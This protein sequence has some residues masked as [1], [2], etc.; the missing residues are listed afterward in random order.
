MN[1]QSPD[2]RP[3]FASAARG[4]RHVFVNRLAVEASIGIHQHEKQAKQEIWLTIDAG[5]LE[6][7]GDTPAN[8]ADVVCYE[9]ICKTATAL[10]TDGHIDLVETLAEN[11][12][13]ALMQDTRIVQIRV[14][15]EK[16]QAIAKAASVG[17]AISRLRG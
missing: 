6:D 17:I 9:D 15:I 3:D 8:I 4:L 5:V 12:A 2:S 14:Q 13:D 10:A 11:I 1:Q 16:P 7:A